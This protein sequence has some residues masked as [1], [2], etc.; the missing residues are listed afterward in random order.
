[1]KNIA[2]C[3][4]TACLFFQNCKKTEAGFD[5]TYRRAFTIDVGLNTIESHNFKFNDIASDTAVFFQANGGTSS[6]LVKQ[7]VPRSM[8]IRTVFATD[9]SRLAFVD[10]V[11][12]FI[13]DPNRPQL[14]ELPIFYRTDI[15]LS[16][17]ARIDL[18]P[19]NV[20]VQKFLFNAR[21]YSMRLNFRFRETPTRSVDVEWNTDFLAK[22]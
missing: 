11:E 15:P 12:V 4:L 8:N 16:T 21:T 6:A 22:I 9:G 3:L 20:D 10:R 13:S 2:F 14:G 7:L 19:E 17:D 18:F 1:M 5:L